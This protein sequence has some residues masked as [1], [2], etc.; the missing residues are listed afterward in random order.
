MAALYNNRRDSAEQIEDKPNVDMI[1]RALDPE[2]VS[3]NEK[4]VAA[5]GKVD[6]SGFA[7]KSD[8]LEIKLVK[9]LDLYIMFSLWSMYF[10]N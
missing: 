8:P 3:I 4:E 1:E 7:Q 9:K 5:N 10:M 2:A 6:Y